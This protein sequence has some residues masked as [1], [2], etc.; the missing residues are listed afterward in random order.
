LPGG[1]ITVTC[2]IVARNSSRLGNWCVVQ[3]GKGPSRESP[4]VW[5]SRCSTV[6]G[7]APG[8]GFGTWNQGSSL[9]TGSSRRSF[10]ASRSWRIAVAVKSLDTEPMRNGVVGV[11]GTPP[12][13]SVVP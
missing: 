3:A 5:V 9:T 12:A 4:E 10:P 11:S 2:E 6:I 1:E 8:K 7:G 13:R